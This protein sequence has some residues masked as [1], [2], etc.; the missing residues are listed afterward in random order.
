MHEA[1]KAIRATLGRREEEE[2]KY[3][4]GLKSGGGTHFCVGSNRDSKRD[5]IGRKEIIVMKSSPVEEP[6]EAR[7]IIAQEKVP[8]QLA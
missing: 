8:Q 6:R 1:E 5:R 4:F 2:S 7:R 3:V